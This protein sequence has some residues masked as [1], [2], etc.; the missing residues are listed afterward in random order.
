MIT[1]RKPGIAA[2]VSVLLSLVLFTTGAFAQGAD[3]KIDHGH[4]HASA[5][6]GVLHTRGVQRSYG[7]GEGWGDG[8]DGWGN[9]CSGGDCNGGLAGGQEFHETVRCTAMR[10][11]RSVQ[12]C[13]VGPWGRGCRSVHICRKVNVC[14]RCR[15]RSG[16]IGNGWENSWAARH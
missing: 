3:Q 12:E 14:H 13:H 11:C 2:V 15:T 7:W 5:R 10:E 1:L 4:I 8:G 9:G 16:W 6:A